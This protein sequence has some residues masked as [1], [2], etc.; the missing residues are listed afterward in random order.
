[1][2]AM[3]RGLNDISCLKTQ[4]WTLKENLEQLG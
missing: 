2:Y 1:M 4:A 3:S